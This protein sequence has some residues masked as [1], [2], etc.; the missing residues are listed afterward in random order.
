MLGK[1]LTVWGHYRT[2][3]KLGCNKRAAAVTGN[4]ISASLVESRF[5]DD[6]KA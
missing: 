1:Y 2:L 3:L 4:A 5:G 6:A